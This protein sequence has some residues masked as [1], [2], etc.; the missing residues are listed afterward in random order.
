[1]GRFLLLVALFLGGWL[2]ASGNLVK[3][4]PR[5]VGTRVEGRAV[6]RTSDGVETRFTRVGALDET[7][8]LFGGDAT[9]RRGSLTHA[10]TSGLPIR[11]ARVIAARYPDFHR[12]SSPGAAQAKNFIENV[13]F[14]ATDRAAR[15][16]LG[17]ALA[18]FQ[19]RL[20]QNGDRT[21]VRVKGAPLVLDSVR[22]EHDGRDVTGEIEPLL[23]SMDLA[24]AER[25]S[26]VDCRELLR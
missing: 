4:D 21:C 17:E 25:V 16:T 18:L 22:L 5:G 1:M 7:W 26:I 10:T 19:E 6:V 9:Q 8:M 23:G 20:G 13:A 11:H 12:C 24:L 3:L 14:V 2:V 15:D